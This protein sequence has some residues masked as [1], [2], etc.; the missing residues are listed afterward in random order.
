[1]GHEINQDSPVPLLLDTHALIWWAAGN[2]RLPEDTRRAIQDD[3]DVFVS[4][5]SVFEITTK[6]TIG[7]LP[8]A[9]LIARDVPAYIAQQDFKPL[10]ISVQ[11]AQVAG[12]LPGPSRD[13]FD[14][15]LIAQAMVENLQ[16]VS[17]EQPF[18]AYPVR[19]LW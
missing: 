3:V 14:R 18:D 4:A 15:L 13:P 5:V 16:L 7:K 12:T 19:R 2:T 11:H 6:F 10:P 8:Q 1:M 17:I 9:A